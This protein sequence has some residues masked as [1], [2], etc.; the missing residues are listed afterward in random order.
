MPGMI[1]N[2]AEGSV[3]NIN[4]PPGITS[5]GVVKKVRYWSKVKK[6]G[7]AGTLDPLATGVLIVLTGKATKRS[8]EFMEQT[9]E[10]SAAIEFGKQSNTDDSEGE[11]TNICQVPDIS[12]ETISNI[13]E[14][15]VGE[16]QQVPPMFSALR[17]DGKRLYKLARKGIVVEREARP[18]TVYDIKI[19]SWENP[20]LKLTV[21]CGRGTYIRSLARDLGNDLNV[22]GILTSLVRTRIGDHCLEDSWD[23]NELESALNDK[24]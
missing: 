11:I 16:I 6:V 22:G 2:L 10:Y 23:F 18:V 24:K 1:S 3:L 21:T 12:L 19:D 14:K 20:V 13:V 4:K 5:F 15:Y 9:K 17:K 7:H 8:A